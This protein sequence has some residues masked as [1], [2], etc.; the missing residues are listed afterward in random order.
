MVPQRV[1]QHLAHSYHPDVVVALEFS[2]TLG[3]PEVAFDFVLLDLVLGWCGR[4]AAA[5][6]VVPVIVRVHVRFCIGARS[7]H[8]W[9][10]MTLELE[11]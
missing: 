1:L 9:T 7:K 4:G 8:G 2:L 11:G 3:A 5:A 10:S 6:P